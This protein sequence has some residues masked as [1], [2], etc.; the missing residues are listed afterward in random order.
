MQNRFFE[1]LEEENK[2]GTSI[3]FSSHILTEIQRMCKR[4]AII[5]NGEINAVE[6]I[7]SL[8]K[9]QMKK[10]RFIFK[11]KPDI[12]FIEGVQNANWMNNKLTFEYVGPVSL[13]IKWM[14]TLDLIDAVLEEPD[15]ETIF[16]NY[17]K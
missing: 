12:D 15:L 17:Y 14:N 16:M 6:E 2:K 4:A 9:K 3:F 8:L 5:R 1:L 7:Q 10:A 13:L 11:N